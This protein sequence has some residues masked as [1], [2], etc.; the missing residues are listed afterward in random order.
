MVTLCLCSTWVPP[1]RCCLFLADPTWVS[2]RLQFSKHCSNMGLY[3]RTHPSGTAPHG[4]PQAAALPALLS[5]H[6]LQL[7]L[8][9]CSCRDSAWAAAFFS[10][11]HCC[12]VFTFLNLLSQ[13]TPSITHAS[14]LAAEGPFWSSWSWLW[15][16]MGQCWHC[17]QG[18]PL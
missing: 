18:P 8:R 14:T 17:S 2:H 1:M 11:I 12:I 15:S 13:S 9:A 3:H 16:D 5:Y 7:W 6:E 4:S 10:H